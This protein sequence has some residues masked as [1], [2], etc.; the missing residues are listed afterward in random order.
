MRNAARK[1]R[2]EYAASRLV[3]QMPMANPTIEIFETPSGIKAYRKTVAKAVRMT[4]TPH[5]ES[6][7][8][9]SVSLPFVSILR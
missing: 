1:R 8:Y 2:A 6:T 3:A 5:F 7:A 4:T 9:A